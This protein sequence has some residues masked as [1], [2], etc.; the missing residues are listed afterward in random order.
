MAESSENTFTSYLGPEF[1]Q[2][3][4][5]Q[6]LVEP[7]FAEKN[8]PNLAVEYFDDPNLRRLFIIILEYYKEHE[9]VPNLQNQ[10]IQQAI[11]TYKT[12]NNR[13]EEESLYSVLARVQ[14][15]NERVLN[16]ETQY[17]GDVVRKSTITFIKQQEW[18]KF[19]EF[20]IDKTK[21]GDIRKKHILGDI[22]E[23]QIK[24][25][26][27]GDEEDAGIEVIDNIEKA[28][29]KEFRQPIPTGVNVLDAVTGG[30]LGKGEIGVILTPSGVGKTTLLTKI[31]NYA[32]EAEKNVLQIIFEDTSEQIQRKHFAIWSK[33]A[34][35]KMDDEEEN[36]KALKICNDKAESMKGKG[37]LLIKRFGQEN[38]T[39]LDI[40]NWMIRHQKKYGIKFD[41]LVLDYLDCL[42]SHKKVNDRNEAELQIVKSFEALASDFDIPAWTAIQSN[43]SGF[44]SEYVEAH[45]TGGS[46]KRIQK[47]HL[48]MSVA[49]TKEQKEAQLAN[50]RIIKARFAQDGQTF[51]DCIFNNDTMEIRIEDDRYSHYQVNKYAKHHDEKDIEALENNANKVSTN[52]EIHRHLS[53]FEEEAL[54]KVNNDGVKKITDYT[55]SE[56]NGLLKTNAEPVIEGDIGNILNTL[57]EIIM[58]NNPT[59]GLLI[60]DDAV[61]DTVNDTVKTNEIEN[62][63]ICTTRTDLSQ[64]ELNAIV[65]FSKEVIRE[66]ENNAPFEWNGESGSTT[67]E[68]VNHSEVKVEDIPIHFKQP[69][70]DVVITMAENKIQTPISEE[71]SKE[72]VEL[73]DPDTQNSHPSV[74]E[75]LRKKALHQGDITK[76]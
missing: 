50:I 60:I 61:T 51:N 30:G 56:L 10:S 75:M 32:Y 13:I 42:E 48:F 52:I 6:L 14:L 72:I 46:I 41:L 36:K 65:D 8:L 62:I 9:K 12:P 49:K 34:L 37:V 63:H 28:L 4:M 39:M 70:A 15:W 67:N 69:P 33:V 18:R 16:K 2:K 73:V 76:K 55:P 66:P 31:A 21:N 17:D 25:S 27:I 23:R 38:T 22:D 3:L 53:Q 24:I 45:Q 20:I 5:W 40:R 64:T 29:R 43:R 47:A 58:D 44:D 19:A 1:Q 74:H 7:E 54:K 71:K 57:K 59:D 35:S 68:V 26:H 11:N